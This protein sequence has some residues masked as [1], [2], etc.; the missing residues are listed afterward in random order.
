M[1]A[2]CQSNESLY[3]KWSGSRDWKKVGAANELVARAVSAV[4]LTLK[5]DRTFELTDGGMPYEGEWSRS[6]DQI[7]LNVTM[8]LNKRLDLESEQVKQAA[9]FELKVVGDTLKFKQALAEEVVELKK[10][11]LENAGNN[12]SDR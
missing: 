1:L 11:P 5:S 2:G 3:G 9:Q 12:K 7:Y 8:I 10:K 6:G 4:D